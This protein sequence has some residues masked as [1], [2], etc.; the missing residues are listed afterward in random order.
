[1]KTRIRIGSRG[2]RLA[3]IQAET[4]KSVLE[5]TF[6][7]LDIHI[8]T[9]KTKG[10]RILNSPLSKIGGKGLFTKELE[11]KLLREEI[12]LAVHSLKDMPAELPDGL[13]LGAVLKREDARD[14]F[15]SRDGRRLGEFAR[16]DRVATSSLRRRAQLLHFNH[17]LTIID[18]RG[19]IDTRLNK[20]NDGD[21]DGM[22][23]AAAGLIRA[24]YQHLITEYLE[25]ALMLPAACQGIIGI[26]LRVHDVETG[27]LLRAV[28]H[29]TTYISALAERAF[30]RKLEGGCQ[31]PLGCLSAIT[32]ARFRIQGMLADIDGT[33]II[34]KQGEGRPD[35]AVK[36]AQ[37]VAVSILE[38]GGDAI[39]EEIRRTSRC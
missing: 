15:I 2:S 20:M 28:D 9:V 23:L 19:N 11:D 16:K 22:V 37:Q 39:L 36:V 4:V 21:C 30:L 8:L 14:I 31:V 38:S 34:K 10:D 12:D 13:M 24:G 1:M 5:N 18:I 3:L 35:E 29:E 25:P 17:A 32:D 26:E 7:G 27:N 33:R 6:P